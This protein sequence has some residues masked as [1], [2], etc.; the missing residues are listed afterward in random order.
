MSCSAVFRAAVF[1]LH[2]FPLLFSAVLFLLSLYCCSPSSSHRA[3]DS[4][5]WTR[6]LGDKFMLGSAAGVRIGSSKGKKAHILPQ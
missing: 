6:V 5:P 1:L 4:H 3:G 2:L